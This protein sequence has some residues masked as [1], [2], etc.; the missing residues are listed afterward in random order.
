LPAPRNVRPRLWYGEAAR[1]LNVSVSTLY[2]L[3]RDGE[4]VPVRPARGR[5][6]FLVAE[7]ERYER[8]QL[9]RVE[10]ERRQRRQAAC[11]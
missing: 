2:R 10:T 5:P 11:R 3:I 1:H 8:Q 6:F 9:R 4:V 7:L